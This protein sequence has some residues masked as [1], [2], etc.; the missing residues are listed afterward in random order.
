MLSPTTPDGTHMMRLWMKAYGAIVNHCLHSGQGQLERYQTDVHKPP[1]SFVSPEMLTFTDRYVMD[2]LQAREHAA[3]I[4][5]AVFTYE[6]AKRLPLIKTPTLHI[7]ADSPYEHEFCRRG[8]QLT[9][10]ISGAQ[11][12]TLPDSDD[13]AAEFK[14]PALAQLILN[15]LATQRIHAE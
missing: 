15:F 4:S 10:L 13:N 7:Q 5:R 12:T 1:H 8:T 14:S 6:T 11:A 3:R 9:E 2:F